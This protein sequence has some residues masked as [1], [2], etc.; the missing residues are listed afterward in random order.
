MT[1]R[2]GRLVRDAA[3]GKVHFENRNAGLAGTSLEMVNIRE[4]D[5]F[6]AGNKCVAV[7]SEAASSGISLHADR[8]FGNQKRRVRSYIYI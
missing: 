6:N 1:G 4:R 7:I 8:R 3:T 2:K 5:L